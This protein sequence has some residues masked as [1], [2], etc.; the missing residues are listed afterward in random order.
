[1][2]TLIRRTPVATVRGAVWTLVVT[3]FLFGATG[4]SV[5]FVGVWRHEASRAKAADSEASAATEVVSATNEKLQA[6]QAQLRRTQADLKRRDD[7]L[8]RVSAA[9]K[10]VLAEAGRLDSASRHLSA[11]GAALGDSVAK[12]TKA[13]SALSV[14]LK[15]TSLAELDPAYV[16]AQLS[17]LEQAVGSLQARSDRLRSG[18]GTVTARRQALSRQIA[19]LQRLAGAKG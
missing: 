16:D 11:D 17:Y 14:Y 18:S 15:Q 10:P 5:L 2:D 6:V 1:M 12:L 7:R 19:A 3:A 9:G 13:V 4:A 8:A